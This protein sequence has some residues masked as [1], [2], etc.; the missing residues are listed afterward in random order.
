MLDEKIE[1][2]DKPRYVMV[3]LPTKPDPRY[4]G[5]SE[6]W[7]AL[8]NDYAQQGYRVVQV[9]QGACLQN[10]DVIPNILMELVK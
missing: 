3:A 7:M 10:Y 9:I 8:V 6:K 1:V 2:Q 4:N 5:P